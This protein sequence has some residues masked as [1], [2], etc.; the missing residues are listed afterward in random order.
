MVQKTNNSD[1]A[2]TSND[3]AIKKPKNS[4]DLAKV[5]NSIWKTLTMIT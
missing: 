4:R 1:V 2:A 3:K 5:E